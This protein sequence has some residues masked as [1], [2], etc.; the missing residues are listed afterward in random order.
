MVCK[1]RLHVY[2]QPVGEHG[3]GSGHD[4]MCAFWFLIAC[5]PQWATTL[6]GIAECRSLTCCAIT[7]FFTFAIW[8]VSLTEYAGDSN[9]PAW[10]QTGCSA[11]SARYF[12]SR[13]STAQAMRASLLASATAATLAPRRAWIAS[14]QRES[15]SVLPVACRNT[16]RAP[17]MSKVRRY[18]L[19]RL[20]MPKNPPLECSRGVSSKLAAIC[21]FETACRR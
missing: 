15:R 8:G 17:R 10:H 21:R 3:I 16:V 9:L 6:G 5:R 18:V 1:G 11:Q 13:A 20:V 4:G 14:A 19:P 12:R 7:C 2:I